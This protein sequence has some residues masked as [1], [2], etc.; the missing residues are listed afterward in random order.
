MHYCKVS[1][2]CPVL[3]VIYLR[4]GFQQFTALISE[5]VLLTVACVTVGEPQPI[6]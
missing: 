6:Q 1:G 3:L 4:E 2:G 5:L